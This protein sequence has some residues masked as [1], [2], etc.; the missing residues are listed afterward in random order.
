MTQY[1]ADLARLA[2]RR[3]DRRSG[4]RKSRSWRQADARSAPAL[5]SHGR[6]YAT[7]VSHVPQPA[8]GAAGSGVHFEKVVFAG[9]GNRCFWQA[10]FWSVAAAAL[11]LRPTRVAAVSAGAAIACAVLSQTFFSGFRQYKRA[12]AANS[13]N[14]YLR[15][16]LSQQPLFPHGSMYRDAILSSINEHA[17]SRLHRGPEISILVA[18]PPHWASP[19]V[20]LLLGMIA[21][22]IDDW[23]GECVHS[24]A[25]CR[26]GFAPQFLSVRECATPESLA[27]LIIASSCVPPLTPLARRNGRVFFDG[28]FVSNVPAFGVS[29][30]DGQTLVLLTRQ[31]SQ[32]P[33]V[34]GRTYVQPSRPIPVAAWDYTDDAA[35][36]STFDLGRR[37]AERFCASIGATA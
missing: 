2:E 17:L 30:G 10:G 8:H 29:G 9:G 15:N 22:G 31:F 36:Q 5:A 4:E 35:V 11:D 27:D 34:A 26:I 6:R 16:L 14:V 33:S 7:H 28:G 37:D 24:S 12:L 19:P 23:S 25:A 21:V 32:L 13:S 18:R 1:S 3:A 20:A